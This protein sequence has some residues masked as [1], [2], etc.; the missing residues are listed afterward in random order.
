MCHFVS[1][2]LLNPIKIMRIKNPACVSESVRQSAKARPWTP[3]LCA[4]VQ[5]A[6]EPRGEQPPRTQPHVVPWDGPSQQGMWAP[7]PHAVSHTVRYG[8]C[9]VGPLQP[10]SPLLPGQLE[11]PEVAQRCRGAESGARGRVCQLLL[12]LSSCSATLPKVFL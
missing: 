9:D 2:K 11:V 6:S 10:H 12:P 4:G 3:R 1:S 7:R 5:G 8:G